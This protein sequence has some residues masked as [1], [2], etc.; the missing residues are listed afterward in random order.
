ML[1]L[2]KNT[3]LCFDLDN[4][5]YVNSDLNDAILSKIK[6]YLLMHVKETEIDI[7]LNEFSLEHGSTLR[8]LIKNK[9]VHP[10]SYL[11][12]IHNIDVENY[13]KKDRNLLS[14]LNSIECK[15][16][17]LTNSYRPYT[18]KV[19]QCLGIKSA[20]PDTSIFDVES[21]GYYYKNDVKSFRFFFRKTNFEPKNCILFD[22]QCANL[23]IA[24]KMN[25]KTVLVSGENYEPNDYDG[26]I[27]SIHQLSQLEMP[28]KI[29]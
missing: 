11:E 14:I 7:I 15:K 19:L 16:V 25:M 28:L 10:L 1:S 18:N 5:L 21:M 2:N 29:E 24:K 13:L 27:K 26:W 17:I 8:G 22:D 9:Q 20:F 23:D 4:T 6:E 3:I 12:Y